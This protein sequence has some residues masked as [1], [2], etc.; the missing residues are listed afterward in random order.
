MKK[1]VFLFLM[2]LGFKLISQDAT[3]GWFYSKNIQ[4]TGNN[5]YKYFFIDKD[6]YKYSNEDLSDIRIVDEMNNFMPYYINVGFKEEKEEDILY[7]SKL[8]KKS[9]EMIKDTPITNTIFDYQIFY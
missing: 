5:K 4:I 9:F 8:I 7:S 6:I 2:F 1:I 3:S